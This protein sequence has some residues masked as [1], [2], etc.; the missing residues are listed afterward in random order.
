[1]GKHLYTTKN[2]KIDISNWEV[3]VYLFKS[4]NSVV[5]LIKNRKMKFVFIL[6]VCFISC[7]KNEGGAVLHLLKKE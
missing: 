2:T 7:E 5:K 1:M 3:G 4:N 6:S